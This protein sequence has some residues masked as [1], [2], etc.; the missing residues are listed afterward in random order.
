MSTGELA[1]LDP[2]FVTVTKYASQPSSLWQ[3]AL[4]LSEKLVGNATDLIAHCGPKLAA[5]AEDTPAPS[6]RRTIA[7]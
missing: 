6:A 2:T 1:A 7:M 4:S 5:L 3:Y